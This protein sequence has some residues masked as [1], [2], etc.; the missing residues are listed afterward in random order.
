MTDKL[1]FL[2]LYM[3]NV[4]DPEEVFLWTPLLTKFV[5]ITS[6]IQPNH[7]TTID[8]FRLEKKK[9]K[10]THLKPKPYFSSKRPRKKKI[11]KYAGIKKAGNFDL[12]ADNFHGKKMLETGRVWNSYFF[13]FDVRHKRHKKQTQFCLFT[14]Y[15]TLKQTK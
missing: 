6:Q 7:R 8:R 11:K 14:K 15:E 3:T 9:K 5:V 2:E 1:F 13:L 4:R 10:K 12:F